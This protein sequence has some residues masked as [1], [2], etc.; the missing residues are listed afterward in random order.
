[1]PFWLRRGRSKAGQNAGQDS[2]AA[3][4]PGQVSRDHLS[5]TGDHKD[6]Q[7]DSSEA[8]RQ[9]KRVILVPAAAHG[10]SPTTGVEPRPSFFRRTIS[11]LSTKVIPRMRSDSSKVSARDQG[12]QAQPNVEGRLGKVSSGGKQSN[13]GAVS[14]ETEH[15][16]RGFQG[17]RQR[18]HTSHHTSGPHATSGHEGAAEHNLHL[19][20]H[21][22]H[23]HFPHILHHPTQQT[24]TSGAEQEAE[25]MQL[26]QKA[27]KQANRIVERARG[28][29]E[30]LMQRAR[31]EAEEEIKAI[32]CELEEEALKNQQEGNSGDDAIRAATAEEESRTQKLLDSASQNMEASVAL[33][34]DYV[35][36]VDTSLSAERRGALI[37]LKRNPPDFLRKSMAKN[38][39]SERR[40]I[41][42]RMAKGK[43]NTH[44][45]EIS[46]DAD[47]L[48]YP[49]IDN[50]SAEQEEAYA[51]I[52]G[53]RTLKEE[54]E[55][56]IDF[57]EL[58]R[59]SPLGRFSSAMQSIQ[60][61]CGCL[62][63]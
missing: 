58:E 57:D 8:A 5:L 53:D 31:E 3:A 49:M 62:L 6:E 45:S 7:L 37:N 59:P 2:A 1:M 26:L 60:T 35:L 42:E 27:T 22:R 18:F 36:T 39:P 40:M 41:A 15:A 44:I 29:R 54:E 9:S 19:P 51:A 32:R 11:S 34:V 21:L 43:R 24:S 56:Y 48:E 28:E 14:A 38:Y 10:A 16:K 46:W 63:G 17:L 20:L 25:V 47:A 30:L 12:Q 55:V 52:L 4:N 13:E 61:T 50:S 33:C 23:L